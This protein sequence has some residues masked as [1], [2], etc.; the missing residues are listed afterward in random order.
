MLAVFLGIFIVLMVVGVPVI[1]A[2]GATALITSVILWG[3]GGVPLNILVQQTVQ[4]LNSFT[5]LAIPMFMLAGQLMNTGG[6]T[7]RI[8]DFCQAMVGHLPGGLGHVNILASVIFSGMS[9]SAA[10]DAGGLGVM[11]IKA[12]EDQGFDTEFSAAVTASSSLIGPIIPPSVPLVTY[13]VMAGLNVTTLFIGGLLPGI[14]MAVGMS[15]LVVYYARKRHY[16]RSPRMTWGQKW[17]AFLRAFPS[18]MTPIII[19]GG[20]WS[21]IFTPTEASSI[22]IAYAFVL[23]VLIYREMNM[24]D[25]WVMAKK[26]VV[27]CTAILAILAF[28]KVYSY[29]LTRTRLPMLLA[30]A[31]FSITTNP[32]LIMFLLIGFLLIVGCFMNTLSSITLFTPIFLPMLQTCGVN[33]YA[34]GLI[35]CLILMIGQLT[36]PF[37]IVL[38]V[39]TKLTKLDMMRLVKECLP[40]TVPVL[41]VAILIVFFPQIVTFLPGLFGG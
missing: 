34:F 23:I 15:V 29:V 3:F 9:G 33:L 36:P 22:A 10:A 19:I 20:I 25:V 39:I 26:S 38:F 24:K 21:G 8:F 11:E 4:G 17:H 35:M 32:T 27:D 13:G 41:I 31:V 6:V 5:T 7:K 1:F 18:L 30:D 40:F 2:M 37:G 16:P 12:M 14:L 28:V